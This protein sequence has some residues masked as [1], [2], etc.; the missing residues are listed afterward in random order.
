MAFQG[1][2]CLLHYFN[3]LGR[4]G[5][6]LAEYILLH[7]QAHSVSQLKLGKKACEESLPND[8]ASSNTRQIWIK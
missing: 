7:L 2:S 8:F 3:K 6:V 5:I 1:A 4:D